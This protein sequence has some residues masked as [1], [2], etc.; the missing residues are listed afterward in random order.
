MQLVGD[1]QFYKL[2]TLVVRRMYGPVLEMYLM[3]FRVTKADW[4]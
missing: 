2:K 1:I 3:Y 4:S